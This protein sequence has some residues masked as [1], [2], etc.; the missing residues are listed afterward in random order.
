MH[1]TYRILAQAHIDQLLREAAEARR[2]AE[3]RRAERPGAGAGLGRRL[4]SHLPGG[5]VHRPAGPPAVIATLSPD[6]A[7]SA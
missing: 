1:E 2:T 3:A 7:C 5:R 4:W 6:G